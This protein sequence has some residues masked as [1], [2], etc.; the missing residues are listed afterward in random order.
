MAWEPDENPGMEFWVSL[1]KVPEKYK[2]NSTLIE[3]ANHVGNNFWLFE[4]D[5][6]TVLNFK[7]EVAGEAAIPGTPEAQE[8]PKE[9]WPEFI[10]Y[11]YNVNINA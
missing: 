4:G 6:E 11:Y 5:H 8:V 10:E 7:Y 2:D 1:L 3:N 9:H